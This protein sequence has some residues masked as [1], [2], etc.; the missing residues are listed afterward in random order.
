M[1]VYELS[2]KSEDE[3]FLAEYNYCKRPLAL[4]PTHARPHRQSENGS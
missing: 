2:P 1:D 4:F 3:P